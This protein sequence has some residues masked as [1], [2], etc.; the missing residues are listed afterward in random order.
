MSKSLI[1][2]AEE[3]REDSLEA[4]MRRK[5][6]VTPYLRGQGIDDG[7]TFNTSEL[8]ETVEN[9]VEY[10][11]EKAL[12]KQ[13]E[14]YEEKLKTVH[15]ALQSSALTNQAISG[16]ML[17]IAEEYEK[18]ISDL[19]LQFQMSQDM[20]EDRLNYIDELEKEL[21]EKHFEVLKDC[22]EWIRIGTY[23]KPKSETEEGYNNANEQLRDMKM[24]YIEADS[25]D[26]TITEKQFKQLKKM[27]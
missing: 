1:P 6:E 3:W 5:S 26:G 20:F 27:I 23:T 19:E 4:K 15:E 13:A 22:I 7:E 11:V 10:F 14:E 24:Q 21:K 17:S 16:K 12:Q 25:L 18:K 9:A 2:Q 8:A